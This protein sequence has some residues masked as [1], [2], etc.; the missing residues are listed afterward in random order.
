MIEK[1]II[2]FVKFVFLGLIPF[3]V[4][5]LLIVFLV[6]RVCFW[7][8]LLGGIGELVAAMAL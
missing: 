7:F 2:V 3:P 4:F 5:R 6:G 8:C 1:N